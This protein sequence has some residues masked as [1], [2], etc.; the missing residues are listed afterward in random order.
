MFLN[1]AIEREQKICLLIG[2][3]RLIQVGILERL[4]FEGLISC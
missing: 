4:E 3:S 2:P 1:R